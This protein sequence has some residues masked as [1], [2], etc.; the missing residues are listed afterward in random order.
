[1]DER[2]YELVLSNLQQGAPDSDRRV[3]AYARTQH[4]RPATAVLRS[5]QDAQGVADRSR[6][7]VA[8]A[9]DIPELLGKVAGLISCRAT[10]RLARELRQLGN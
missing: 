8:Q 4:Y 3:L 7:V 2:E 10:R 6:Q 5:Y 1:M 9:E